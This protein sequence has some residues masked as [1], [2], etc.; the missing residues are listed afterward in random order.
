MV[1]GWYEVTTRDKVSKM[2]L[3]INKNKVISVNEKSGVLSK[4]FV[5]ELE[6]ERSGSLHHLPCAP[7]PPTRP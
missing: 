6:S 2:T 7:P 1:G 3:P 4:W 5:N